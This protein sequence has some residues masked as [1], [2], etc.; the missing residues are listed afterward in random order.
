MAGRVF[1][2]DIGNTNIKVGIAPAEPEG[3]A[4]GVAS[5]VPE[6]AA[7]SGRDG[8]GLG[9]DSGQGGAPGRCGVLEKGT[10]PDPASVLE[11]SYVLPTDPRRTVD[12]LGFF[13][14][15]ICRHAGLCGRGFRDTPAVEAALVVSVV[16]SC[17]PVLAGA[18]E[19]Y[20]GVRPLFV[21]RDLPIPLENRYERPAEVG[22]D[23]LVSAYGARCLFDNEVVV[24][25]DFGTATTF[26]C[27][28]G[29]AYLGGLICPGV[30]SSASALAGKT[31]KLPQIRLEIG[32]DAPVIGRSTSESLNQGFIFGFA[33]M[34]D[35]LVAR[36][37][38]VLGED[39]G[40]VATGG[41]AEKIGR[42]AEHIEFVR[43]DLLLEGLLRLYR[44][45]RTG[46]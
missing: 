10:A 7:A 21:P 29:D 15:E 12:S 41:F 8:F 17:D 33:A 42:V 45:S 9:A 14:L 16:P 24:G 3:V 2:F 25:V 11:T 1:L 32:S 36:L 28:R 4:G 20:L 39:M 34:V 38:T 27:V 26:D 19:R 35:G 44:T 22:A 18:C 23:R 13:L 43:P 46:A 40:V 5:R 6:G 31:A 37:R 30:Y